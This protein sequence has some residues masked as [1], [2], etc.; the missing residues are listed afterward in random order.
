[1]EFS[2]GNSQE[3]FTAYTSAKTVTINLANAYNFEMEYE[4]PSASVFMQGPSVACTEGLWCENWWR[5]HIY[6]EDDWNPREK[7]H[8]IR[9]RQGAIA[10]IKKACPGK[11]Y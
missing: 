10:L 11:P 6:A 9:R 3:E 5:N 1:M 4:Y 8:S 7:P 2:K